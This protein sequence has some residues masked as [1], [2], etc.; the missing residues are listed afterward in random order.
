[1]PA[2]QE[3][4]I[5]TCPGPPQEITA[6]MIAAMLCAAFII[7]T[8]LQSGLDKAFDYKGNSEWLKGQF[9]KT[10]LRGTIGILLPVI[11]LGEIGSALFSAWGIVEV[12]L[13]RNVFYLAAGLVSCAG[14]LLMLLFGQRVSKEY[15]GAASLT[16]Y[17][18]VVIAG[19]IALALC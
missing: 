1:M 16:G 2:E 14:V 15:A 4:K 7:I 6:A 11:M 3:L 12:L 9:S 5:I 18:L 8:F 13:H 19:L 10:F 17:F